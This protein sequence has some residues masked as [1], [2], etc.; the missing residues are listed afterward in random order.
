TRSVCSAAVTATA[1][2][3]VTVVVPPPAAIV[4]EPLLLVGPLFTVTWRVAPPHAAG[5][6]DTVTLTTVPAVRF[7]RTLSPAAVHRGTEMVDAPSDPDETATEAANPTAAQ[8]RVRNPSPTVRRH[9]TAGLVS[10]G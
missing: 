6:P 7:C 3:S 1:A 2:A 5:R 10:A 4:A 9:M 8:A